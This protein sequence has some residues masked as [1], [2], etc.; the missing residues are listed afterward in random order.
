VSVR[1]GHSSDSEPEDASTD[2]PESPS[3]GAPVP[4]DPVPLGES[5]PSQED[6]FFS[7]L[8]QVAK[9]PDV[10]PASAPHSLLGQRLSHFQVTQRLGAGGMGVVYRAEDA[11][12]RRSVALKV[13]P[14]LHAH[15][16][17]RQQRLLREARNAAAVS[18]P[19]LAAIYEVG[20]EKGVAFIAMEYLEGETLRARLAGPRVTPAEVL[21][22]ALQIAQGLARAHQAGIVHRDL[23]PDNVMLCRDGLIKI[24]D[25]GLAKPQ[26]PGGGSTALGGS[27]PGLSAPE[28]ESLSQTQDGAVAG[29]PRYMSPEQARGLP[30]DAR[31][32]V[33]SFGIMLLELCTGR[34][35]GRDVPAEL[36]KALREKPSA[37][38]GPW[39]SLLEISAGCLYADPARRY[40]D[41]AALLSALTQLVHEGER[42]VAE[43]PL[44][45]APS[46]LRRAVAVVAG[47]GIL[48]ATGA[49]ALL[50]VSRAT[51]GSLARAFAGISGGRDRVPQPSVR[52]LTA[53]PPENAIADAALSPDGKTLAY[54]DR[55]GLWLRRMD[56]V[57]TDAVRLP[58]RFTP[59]SVTWFP[60]GEELL[61]VG[62]LPGV[63]GSSLVALTPTGKARPLG[64]RTVRAPRVSPRGHQV[65]WITPEGIMLG[66]ESMETGTLL[67]P[68]ERQKR[69]DRGFDQLAWSP[70][71]ERLA[72]LR[73]SVGEAGLE[74]VLE[75]VEL[76]GQ[77]VTTLLADPRLALESG[78][79]ALAWAPDGRLFYALAERPPHENGATLWSLEPDP[80]TGRV[81]EPAVFLRPW[82][83]S[84]PDALSISR[85][86]A[87]AY[88]QYESQVDV[89]VA[90]LEDGGRK[91]EQPRRITL[92]DR[93]EQPAAWMPDGNNVLFMSDQDGT[94]DLY[95]QDTTQGKTGEAHAVVAEPDSQTWPGVSTGGAD[96]L[97]WQMAV[98]DDDQPHAATLMRRPLEGGKSVQVLTTERATRDF[99][100]LPP[101]AQVHFRCPIHTR[102]CLL[103]EQEGTELTFSVFDPKTGHR[104]PAFRTR[105]PGI[106]HGWDVSSD[107]RRLAFP[108]RGGRIRTVGLEN[109]VSGEAASPPTQDRIV[110]PQCDFQFVAWAH[111]DKSLFTTGSC[112]GDRPYRVYFV[113]RTRAPRLLWESSYAWVGHPTPSPDGRS[114]ALA[115]KPFDN[116]VWMLSGL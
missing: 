30:V 73:F 21:R 20:E 49:A 72:Y 85:S 5:A 11:R 22:W 78:H 32:D 75:T 60:S 31:S 68:V 42:P 2:K 97:Y 88:V 61:V 100:G 46:R 55:R 89:Y 27:R 99:S 17:S 62:L 18:H 14:P 96:V 19:N 37:E 64:Q 84:Y 45:P 106:G 104:W 25:F 43:K 80:R 107:G 70:D 114:L 53:N 93:N 40:A 86:G 102:T 113:E 69:L 79:G 95:V 15:D 105:E 82:T 34:T 58:E 77:K 36:A 65:A 9:A 1:Q 23:K 26:G 3:G 110:D 7:L 66:P 52:R 57:R 74:A 81:L 39:Q 24:L 111:D 115:V 112:S 83:G 10:E 59:E 54:V 41:G 94:H 71:G 38:E 76:K 33:Y 13:L 67:V 63:E 8:K 103:S 4:L 91:M 35:L 116:D 101:P 98:Y 56:P 109:G 50:G 108:V 6:S 51:G 87:L 16:R 29:T 44:G 48:A 92:T 47:L 90:S 12:L 28:D